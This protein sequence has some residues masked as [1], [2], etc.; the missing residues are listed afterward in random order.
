MPFR[1]IEKPEHSPNK[2]YESPNS[3]PI[4]GFSKIISG[5]ATLIM[6]K[7]K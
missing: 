7:Y 4:H 1:P 3:V 6:M 5:E 2:L